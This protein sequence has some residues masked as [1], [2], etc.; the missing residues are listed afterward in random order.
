M[1]RAR[2]QRGGEEGADAQDDP[3]TAKSRLSRRTS[4]SSIGQSGVIRKIC[5]PGSSARRPEVSVFFYLIPVGEFKWLTVVSP[6]GP[7]ELELSLEPNANPAAKAF[8]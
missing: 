7:D 1:S 5:D 4:P 2:R 3:R 8:Q 6:D